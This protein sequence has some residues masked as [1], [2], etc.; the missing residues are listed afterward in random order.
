MIVTELNEQH[1]Q[2]IGHAFGYAYKHFRA[3]RSRSRPCGY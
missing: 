3:R 2:D 1:V